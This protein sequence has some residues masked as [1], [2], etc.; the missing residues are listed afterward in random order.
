MPFGLTPFTEPFFDEAPMQYTIDVAVPADPDYVWSEFTRQNTLDW[1][2]ALKRVTY[3]SPQPYG[4]GTTR[5]ATLTG[6]VTLHEN[7]FLWEEDPSAHR[8]R[9]AF[10]V[11]GAS[12]PG[13]KQFGELTEVTLGTDGGSHIV[14]RFALRLGGI[15]LPSALSSRISSLAF[16]SVENDTVKHFS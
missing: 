2:R 9:H 4:P 15:A 12:V 1:C 14:W 6:G 13:M 3:T 10:Y 8:Y 11:E 7:F 5:T 16:G